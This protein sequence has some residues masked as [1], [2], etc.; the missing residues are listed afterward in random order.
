M[1]AS[2]GISDDWS[3]DKD[4]ADRKGCTGVLLD[5]TVDYPTNIYPGLTFLKKAAPVV[6]ATDFEVVEPPTLVKP[7]KD[8]VLKM[9]CEGCEYKLADYDQTFYE[10][11]SQLSIEIHVSRAFMRDLSY[12]Q[13]LETGFAKM[14]KAGFELIDVD[15]EACGATDERTGCIPEF[16]QVGLCTPRHHCQNFL[17][18]KNH[19]TVRPSAMQPTFSLW[20]RV[21]REGIVQWYYETFGV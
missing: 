20:Q 1:F 11:V 13:R 10:R 14:R 17:F 7:G 5:P 16:Q 6:F 12:M 21:W 4:M 2:Y 8:L 15:I 18:A 19:V 3:F 9:D